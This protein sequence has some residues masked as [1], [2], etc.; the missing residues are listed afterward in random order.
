MKL[1]PLL[2]LVVTEW[3]EGQEHVWQDSDGEIRFT[4]DNVADFFP[5]ERGFDVGVADEV[6][7][8]A[9]GMVTFCP[10]IEGDAGLALMLTQTEWQ[11]ARDAAT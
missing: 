2:V 10:N 3:P 5:E 11:E 6:V 1:I 7:E 9:A 4:D 8:A